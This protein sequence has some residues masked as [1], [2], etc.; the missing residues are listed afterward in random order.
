[1]NLLIII[2]MK[3]V[4]TGT[5]KNFGDPN[6]NRDNQNMMWWEGNNDNRNSYYRLAIIFYFCSEKLSFETEN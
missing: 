2:T 3:T 6:K 4:E 1:M 5:K